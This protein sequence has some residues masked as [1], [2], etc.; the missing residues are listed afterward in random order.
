M[1][2]ITTLLLKEPNGRLPELPLVQ[3]Q[4]IEPLRDDTSKQKER[5]RPL[6]F[7]VGRRQGNSVAV[8]TE[9]ALR[10]K[11]TCQKREF[12]PRHRLRSTHAC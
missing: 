11:M 10:G 7:G 5:L 8:A 3:S 2:W 6:G 1:D 9:R 12:M 4:H